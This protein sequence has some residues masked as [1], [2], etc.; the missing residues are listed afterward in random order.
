MWLV[1]QSK[2]LGTNVSFSILNLYQLLPELA[3]FPLRQVGA[4]CF[5]VPVCFLFSCSRQGAV[6]Q[7]LCP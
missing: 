1:S 2:H 5:F 4:L 3:G 6:E 7:D